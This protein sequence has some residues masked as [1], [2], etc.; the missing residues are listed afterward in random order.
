MKTNR[1][2]IVLVVSIILLVG[3]NIISM[4]AEG[5]DDP[6]VTLSYVNLRLDEMKEYVK[7]ELEDVDT[8]G[9]VSEKYIIIEPKD[10]AKKGATIYFTQESTELILRGGK[11]SAIASEN[12]GLADLTAG[13]DLQTGD[14]VPTN[15]QIL[16]AR[17]DGRGIQLEA[18]SWIMIKGDY[19]I[20]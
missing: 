20:K 2:I 1:L 15:H 18:D 17:D 13:I 10:G 11:A 12:G 19:L 5:E 9:A 6:L 16:I 7:N 4:S 3:V 14:N 8:S